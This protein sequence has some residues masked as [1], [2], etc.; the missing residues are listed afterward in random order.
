MTEN[1]YQGLTV[2]ESVHLAYYPEVN[3]ISADEKSLLIDMEKV[4]KISSLGQLAR[5]EAKQPVKQPLSKLEVKISEQL[6]VSLLEVVAEELNIKKVLIVKDIDPHLQKHQDQDIEIGLD[7]QMNE[8]L[9]AE[10]NARKLIREIQNER[11]KLN[12]KPED[13]IILELPEYPTAFHDFIIKK[14]LAK[15]IKKG[16]VLKVLPLP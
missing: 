14:V 13:Y 2:E 16:P 5:V 8:E 9:L 15:E 12:L 7:T 1:V 10:G 4:R 11:K 3:E 6:D